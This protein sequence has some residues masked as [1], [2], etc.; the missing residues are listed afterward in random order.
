[1]LDRLSKKLSE[2][3]QQVSGKAHITEKNIQD[4]IGEIKI[5]LLEADGVL[6]FSTNATRFRMEDAALT[7]LEVEEITA[8]E[9]NRDVSGPPLE[10]MIP[11]YR[12]I[13]DAGRPLL[14][15]GSFT[16]A[17]LGGMLEALTPTGLYLYIMV[18]DLAEIEPLQRVL[19][20]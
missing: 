2:I 12:M 20:M 7:G 11:F 3:V 16:P 19:G 9:V 6:I 15:R 17:E 13:Q 10:V 1:M 14:V 8:F 18:E 5:A 4:A